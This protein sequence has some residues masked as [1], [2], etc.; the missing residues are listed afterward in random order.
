[1]FTCVQFHFFPLYVVSFP[2]SMCVILFLPH[3]CCKL[4]D[5]YTILLPCMQFNFCTL[6]MRAVTG[7]Q[8]ILL[9]CV[10]FNFCPLY[11]ILLPCV[12]FNFFPLYVWA[13]TLLHYT[14]TASGCITLYRQFSWQTQHQYIT[15]K[16]FFSYL[17]INVYTAIMIPTSGFN[18][19]GVW[20]MET[21]RFS[22]NEITTHS[23]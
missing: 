9:L 11:T 15:T 22:K 18:P 20:S 23:I 5:Y 7:L 3:A 21:S 6:C 14:T 1:M 19:F 12:Q 16:C 13:V 8:Y 10:Q 4:D 2:T 17:W